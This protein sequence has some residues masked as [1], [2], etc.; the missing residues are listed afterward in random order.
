LPPEISSYHY[1]Y[2]AAALFWMAVWAALYAWWRPQRRSMLLVGAVLALSGP[3][4][5]YWYFPSYW[6]PH[7]AMEFSLGSW[8]FGI[9]DWL[10]AF[11]LAGI[12]AGIFERCAARLGFEP[13]PRFTPIVLLR[14]TGWNALGLALMFAF[15]SWL[16][17]GP[18]TSLLA[19]ITIV[20]AL[21]LAR[22]KHVAALAALLAAAAG[23]AYWL[24][25]AGLFIQVFPGIF[26]S[27]WNR[28]ALW[29]IR[30][31]GVPEEF[32]WVAATMLFV[33]P[34]LRACSIPPGRRS[35]LPIPVSP[36]ADLPAPANP[37]RPPDTSSRIPFA[38]PQDAGSPL[39]LAFPFNPLLDSRSAA[40]PLGQPV[41]VVEPF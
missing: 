1:A 33:G 6:N 19:A 20:S 37:L 25:Y 41:K 23:L 2:L 21:M 15:A 39:P 3:V 24:F 14:I 17:W 18:A 27:I 12:C 30:W 34:M 35:S 40:H 9:E 4:S 28:D 32:L 11:A 5:E 10:A 38:Q 8:R 13:L 31:L 16:Q 36:S 22:H 29:G 7:F 26:E